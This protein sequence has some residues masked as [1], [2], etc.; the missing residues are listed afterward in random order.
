MT[1][2]SRIASSSQTPYDDDQ[3]LYASQWDWK[4][5]QDNLLKANKDAQGNELPGSDKA[6]GY[7]L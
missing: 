5:N 1:S 2:T 3:A 4:Q 7:L 6:A